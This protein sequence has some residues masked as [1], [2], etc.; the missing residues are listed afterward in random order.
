MGEWACSLKSC[1]M[2]YA[3]KSYVP[4]ADTHRSWDGKEDSETVSKHNKIFERAEYESL[5]SET[6]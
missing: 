6:G 1:N 3:W 5:K 2:K 4:A